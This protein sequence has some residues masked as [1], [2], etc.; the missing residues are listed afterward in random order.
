MKIALVHDWLHVNAGSEKVVSEI[1]DEFREDDPEVYTLFDKLSAADRPKIVGDAPV[2]TSALQRLPNITKYYRYLLPLMPAI[3]NRFRLRGFD[4]IISSSHAV[5]KGFRKDKGTPHICYCHTPMRYVWDLYQ[6][7]ANDGSLVKKILYKLFVRYLKAWDY[8]TAQHVDHFIANSEN[9]RKRIAQN[10]GRNAQVIYPPVRVHQFRLNEQ[11]R[12]DYYLCLG[13]FVPYKRI[14]LVINAFRAMPDKKLLLVGDG[15]DA[16]KISR[17]LQH[18][19]N[20]TWLGYKNDSELIKMMQ[21]AKACIFAAKEDFGIM[22]VEV[23][24]C[25]TPVIAL[26]SGGYQETVVDGET[27]YLFDLQTKESIMKVIQK[28]EKAPLTNHKA[29]RANAERFSSER[30]REEMRSFIAQ[31]MPHTHSEKIVD[32]PAYSL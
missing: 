21:Q 25:G 20:V 26:N 31:C 10:Y 27:G 18:V 19:P 2:H 15:Y 17:L 1:L 16:P 28:F 8:R 5:A 11:A 4:L 30:F 13:R 12:K 23:Q 24:A 7:Y 29:I 3:M 32:E 22:C 6:D 9:V 14:D